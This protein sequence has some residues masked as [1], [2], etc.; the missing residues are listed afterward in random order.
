MTAFLVVVAGG[1]AFYALRHL[2]AQ[3]TEDVAITVHSRRHGGS[4]C[5]DDADDD[6]CDRYCMR[7]VMFSSCWHSR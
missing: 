5:D 1:V 6:C 7:V 4:V 2:A 3:E